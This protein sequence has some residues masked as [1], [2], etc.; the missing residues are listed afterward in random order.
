M[1]CFGARLSGRCRRQP[2]EASRI[3]C[4]IL[5]HLVTDKRIMRPK[6]DDVVRGEGETEA[7]PVKEAQITTRIKQ[8]EW[9]SFILG[10]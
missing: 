6:A 1:E 3:F 9:D 8:P 7:K 4:L 2:T 10:E 5:A